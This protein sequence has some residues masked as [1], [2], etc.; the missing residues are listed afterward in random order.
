MKKSNE[1]KNEKRYFNT[2]VEYFH[3]DIKGF[4][5]CLNDGHYYEVTIDK[6]IRCLFNSGESL[7]DAIEWINKKRMM[8]LL[9]GYTEFKEQIVTI[10]NR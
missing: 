4:N 5:R 6:W 3:M 1:C 8:I 9:N 2:I 10:I 7:E